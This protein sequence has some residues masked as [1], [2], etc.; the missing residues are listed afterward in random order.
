MNNRNIKPFIVVLL[1][2]SFSIICFACGQMTTTTGSPPTETTTTNDIDA[3]LHNLQLGNIIYNAPTSMN[4][5]E[6]TGIQLMLSVSETIDELKQ[7]ITASGDV[8]SA[9]IQVSDVMSATLSA[10]PTVFEI[11]PNTPDTQ[12]IS[13]TETNQW[14]WNV[15]AL[16]PGNQILNLTINVILNGEPHTLRVFSQNI[17]VNVPLPSRLSSFWGS[18]WQWLWTTILLPIGG[19][20]WHWYNKKNKKHNKKHQLKN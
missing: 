12:A 11:T 8:Q 3:I 9:N 1:I 14:S 7:M 2:L 6:T 17:N 16:E 10:S 15:T 4:I 13:S 19:W 20:I 18:N 5:R